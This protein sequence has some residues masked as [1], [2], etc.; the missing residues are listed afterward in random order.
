MRGSPQDIIATIDEFGRTQNYLMNV[1]EDKGKTVCDL[2]AEVQPATMVELGG[3][4]GYSTILFGDAL[5]KAGGKRYF[6][7]E[8]SPEFAA[9]VLSLV[10]L[11]G[12]GDIVKV[13]VGDS[14]ESIRRIHSEGTVDRIDLLFLDHFKP[15]Y[16]P[17]LQ[18]CEQLGLIQQG[19][20]LAADNVIWPGNP[21]YLEYVRSSVKDKRAQFAKLDNISD[22]SAVH[23]DWVDG[24]LM[25]MEQDNTARTNVRGNPSLQYESKLVEGWEPNGE[26]VRV[27][28]SNRN[29]E[30]ILIPNSGRNRDIKVYR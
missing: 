21:F 16:V 1:G 9:I 27:I 13:I 2:I 23:K 7:L 8:R 11:A 12:L 29:Q 5:R 20:V 28:L 17:D 14:A 10:D 30:I 24:Q 26:P 19:S 6:S 4:V 18:L 25:R 22:D 15:F 3:Y